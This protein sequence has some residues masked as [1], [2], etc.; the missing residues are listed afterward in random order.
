MPRQK[1]YLRATSSEQVSA[2]ATGQANNMLVPSARPLMIQANFTLFLMGNPFAA[3]HLKNTCRPFHMA[4]FL[5][6]FIY[7][8]T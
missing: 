5:S 8:D 1:S 2:R 4:S 6:I 3:K 7:V